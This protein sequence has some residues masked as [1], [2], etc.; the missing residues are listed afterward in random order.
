MTVATDSAGDLMIE[1]PGELSGL[2]G[3]L[4]TLPLAEVNIEPVGLRALVRSISRRLNTS[5]GLARVERHERRAVEK[6][7]L[8][9]A[10][11]AVEQH[12]LHVCRALAAGVDQQFFFGRATWKSMFSFMPELVEQLMPVS[13]SQV[14]TSAGRIAVAYDDPIVLL[15]VTVWAISRGSDAVSGELNRGTMEM[16]LAQPVTRFGVLGTQAAVTLGGAALLAA[17]ALVGNERGPGHDH[18]RRN[19]VAPGVRS[20]RRSTCLP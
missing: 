5:A 20:G 7:V 8:R 9:I 14:A 3:W 16:V 17:A 15:L 1:T 10:L 12:G 4:A 11:A 18:A 6:N 19:R 13:F 2:L